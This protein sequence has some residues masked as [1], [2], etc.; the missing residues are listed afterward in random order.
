MAPDTTLLDE[1][2]PAPLQEM[3]FLVIGMSC[4]SCVRRIE[5]AL[6]R[7]EGV[8]QATVNLATEQ[9]T[10]HFDGRRL[11]LAQLVQA[12]EKAGY[13]AGELLDSAREPALEA[14]QAIEAEAQARQR[15]AAAPFPKAVVAM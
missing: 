11:E 8:Q 10:V 15:E 9:A 3:T 14:G 12:V 5:K 2:E 1:Q 7:L 4:A 13:G 6:G